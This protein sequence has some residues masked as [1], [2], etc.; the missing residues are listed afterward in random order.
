MKNKS[1]NNKYIY[2]PL[3]GVLTYENI[4][5]RLKEINL[6]NEFLHL[7]LYNTDQVALMNE[8]LFS[9]LIIRFYGQNEDI[10][11]LSKN[12]QIKVE[13]PNTFIDFLEKFPILTLF[14]TREL[15]ISQLPPLI[16]PQEL[17]SNIQLVANYLKALKENKINTKDLIFPKITPEDFEKRYYFSIKRRKF[18]L[19]SKQNY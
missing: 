11:Y 14:K 9:I 17:D 6:K 1:K 5:K 10:F 13:I 7:D 4:I 12:I 16:V 18:Q 3:G 19:Q 8:F 15:T 2:F